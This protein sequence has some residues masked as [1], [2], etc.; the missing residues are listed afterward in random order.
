[1]NPRFG[2]TSAANNTIRAPFRLTLDVQLDLAPPQTKQQMERWIG[3]GNTNA[4]SADALAKRFQRTVPDP[5]AE[6]M[7][8]ADSL[9]L[10][11]Q[12]IAGLQQADNRYRTHV[13][14]IW[15]AISG[16]LAS[17][18]NAKA[19]ADAFRK[20]DQATDDAWE[21]TRV[22]VQRDFRE[23]LTP[24]QLTML[25]GIS[26]F[27]FNAQARVHIRMYPRGG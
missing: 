26:R 1:V 24:D 27:L 23:I 12:Q 21:I 11:R 14:S 7:Q 5:Y 4:L 2:S 20:T 13:D 9:L 22:T 3:D 17:L 10:T 15:T 8:Q 19:V 25:P 16:Y 18:P 6:L